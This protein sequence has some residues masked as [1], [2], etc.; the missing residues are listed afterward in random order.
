VTI[1]VD[2]GQLLLLN[3]PGNIVSNL[4]EILTVAILLIG[5]LLLFIDLFR[6]VFFLVLVLF[7]SV[8]LGKLLLSLR[9]LLRVDVDVGT[10]IQFV[11]RFGM[12]LLRRFYSS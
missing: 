4:V 5:K 1:K 8:L 6:V 9:V 12:G 11:L 3:S 7:L 10:S 2:L